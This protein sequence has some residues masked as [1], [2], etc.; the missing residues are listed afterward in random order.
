MT[1]LKQRLQEQWLALK[2]VGQAYQE[3]RESL[4]NLQDTNEELT[5]TIDALSRA[6]HRFEF[7]NQPYLSRLRK[8]SER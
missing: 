3:L 2:S 1:N 4:N 7:K 5:K 6:V 8:I